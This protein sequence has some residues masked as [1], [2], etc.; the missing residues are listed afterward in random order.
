[1]DLMNVYFLDEDRKSEIEELL[2]LKGD[3][4]NA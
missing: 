1:M 4:E 3:V 2:C